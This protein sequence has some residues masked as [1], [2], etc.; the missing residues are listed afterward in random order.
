MH[1]LTRSKPPQDLRD[2][3]ARKETLFNSWRTSINCIGLAI[4][5]APP[6]LSRRLLPMVRRREED[7]ALPPY[8]QRRERVQSFD[9]L[10]LISL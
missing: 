9:N 8:Q 3:E 2:E 6:G 7:A 5:R 4:R 1:P 10:P